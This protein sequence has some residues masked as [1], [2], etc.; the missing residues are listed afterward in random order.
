MV[1]RNRYIAA[2]NDLSLEGGRPPTYRQPIF[3]TLDIFQLEMAK[4]TDTGHGLNG[5]MLYVSH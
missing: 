2:N 1:P 4:R 5:R 3:T